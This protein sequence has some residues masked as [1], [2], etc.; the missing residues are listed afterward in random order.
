LIISVFP[1]WRTNYQERKGWIPIKENQLSR[2][3]G[4]DSHYGEPIIKRGRVGFPLR[5]TNY[6]ER[7]GWIPIMEN[8]LS[9]EGGLDSHY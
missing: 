8:Q 2:E 5:R 6:Q 3:G 7:E 4:L 1:L 9:R